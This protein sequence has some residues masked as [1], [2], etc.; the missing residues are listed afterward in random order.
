MADTTINSELN[1]LLISLGKG[2]LQYVG[3]CWPWTDLS[4]VTERQVIESLVAAQAENVAS[5]VEFLQRRRHPIQFGAYPT[6]FTDLHYV[7]LDFLLTQMIDDQKVQV[8]M[9]ER[10]AKGCARDPGAAKLLEHIR[11]SEREILARLERLASERS[12]WMKS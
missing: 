9:V 12:A 1:R 5:L 8:E 7:A 4:A 10:A 6:E 11:T 3:E 2:L